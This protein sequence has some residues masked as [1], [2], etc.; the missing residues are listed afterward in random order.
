MHI[1]S[2]SSVVQESVVDEWFDAIY[3][4]RVGQLGDHTHTQSTN[5]LHIKIISITKFY[6]NQSINQTNKTTNQ[7][8]PIKRHE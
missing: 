5:A 7:I 1:D 2:I 3:E 8:H 4:I 6:T